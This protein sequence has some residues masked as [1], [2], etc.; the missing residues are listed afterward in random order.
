MMDLKQDYTANLKDDKNKTK[1]NMQYNLKRCQ[2]KLGVYETRNHKQLWIYGWY[3]YTV[4]DCK[5][6]SET[7]IV[8][9]KERKKEKR[10]RV[11]RY[12]DNS[13]SPLVQH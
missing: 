5:M 3:L 1:Q 12:R 2:N 13:I 9:I 7:N 4:P 8:S 10:G 6:G 11:S